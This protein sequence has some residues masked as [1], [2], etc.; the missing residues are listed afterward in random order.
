ME[1]QGYASFTGFLPQ[2]ILLLLTLVLVL[3]FVPVWTERLLRRFNRLERNFRG[4][5]IPVCFGLSILFGALLLL[6]VL[7]LLLPRYALLYLP[8]LAVIVGFGV[9]GFIDD[10]RGDKQ[11]K[12]LRGHF[13]AAFRERRITTGFVKAVGGVLLALGV[14]FRSYPTRPDHAL[15]AAGLIA[16]AANAVNL[17]DLRPGRASGIFL[18]SATLILLTAAVYRASGSGVALLLCVAL[19]AV[20]A[21]LRDSR[22]HVMLGDTGSNLLGAS[23][24]LAVAEFSGTTGQITL[25]ALLIGLH[26]LAE[27]A[28][29]TALIEKNRALRTLDRLTGVR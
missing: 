6:G 18:A 15:L 5:Q 4:E 21:W 16:L 17:L 8:W 20:P 2:K 19:P 29:L 26:L 13:R 1:P 25:L 27:R 14:A 12:G 3:V 10:I 11:I 22:A 7:A 23:L 9:L 28:S 24:G